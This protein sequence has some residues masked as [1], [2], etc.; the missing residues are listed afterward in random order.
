MELDDWD[1]IDNNDISIGWKKGEKISINLGCFIL[2]SMNGLAPATCTW[3][4]S[5]EKYHTIILQ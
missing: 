3:I 1:I 2:C 4:D 5:K